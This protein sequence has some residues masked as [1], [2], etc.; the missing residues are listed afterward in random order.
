[1]ALVE[2]SDRN[3]AVALLEAGGQDWQAK[4]IRLGEGDHFP[5][6]QAFARHRLASSPDHLSEMEKALAE[7]SEVLTRFV[8][9][10]SDEDKHVAGRAAYRRASKALSHGREG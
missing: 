3:A 5:I 10:R 1:M 9:S 7:C 6:V 4:E 8:H 2:Q